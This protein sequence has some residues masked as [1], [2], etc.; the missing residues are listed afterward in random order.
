MKR[1]ITVITTLLIMLASTS[2]YAL[3]TEAMTVKMLLDGL[4]QQA[5]AIL[6]NAKY[7]ANGIV[8][9]GA[10][11]VIN[12]VHQV[13]YDYEE[14]LNKTSKELTEQQRQFFEGLDGK[15]TLFFD[16]VEAEHNKVDNTLDNLAIYLSDTM[17]MSKEPRI[18][19]FLSSTGICNQEKSKP[20]TIKFRGKNLHHKKNA[21]VVK[22]E[23]ISPLDMGDNTISFILP[24]SLIAA[25]CATDDVTLIPMEIELHKRSIFGSAMKN[26]KYAVRLIPNDLAFAIVTTKAEQLSVSNEQIITRGGPTGSVSAHTLGGRRCN[27]PSFNAYPDDGYVIDTSSVRAFFN[28]RSDHC[29]GQHSRCS[30]NPSS[31]VAYVD[32]TICSESGPSATC[33]WGAGVQFK[34]QKM[35][36]IT[37]FQSSERFPVLYNKPVVWSIPN[38]MKFSHVQLT[39]F[40]GTEVIY[41]KE[42]MDSLIKVSFDPASKTVVISHN[43]NIDQL[44]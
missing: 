24:S 6:N 44:Y 39:Y 12:T 38:N 4:E 23:R 18:S 40:D 36:P 21:L 3:F 7:S 16:S 29:S 19:R 5:N 13:R 43:L 42:S 27:H 9:N 15:I 17:L 31:R 33:S 14:V 30:A 37:I 22:N 34:Q 8:N 25:N 10:Y 41:E 32:C 2:S 28:H 1:T 20:I 35:E 26:Y 11:N